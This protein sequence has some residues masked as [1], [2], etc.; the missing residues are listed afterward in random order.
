MFNSKLEIANIDLLLNTIYSVVVEPVM[1]N[2]LRHTTMGLGTSRNYEAWKL[3]WAEHL[4]VCNYIASG[5]CLICMYGYYFQSKVEGHLNLLP[6]ILAFHAGYHHQMT[7]KPSQQAKLVCRSTYNSLSGHL[8]KF[9]FYN[10]HKIQLS[11][12]YRKLNL[13]RYTCH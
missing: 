6:N 13:Y 12:F 3:I 8:A 10:K 9:Q 4:S 5:N 1:N 2:P 11:S 7:L